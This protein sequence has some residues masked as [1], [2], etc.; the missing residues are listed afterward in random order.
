MAAAARDLPLPSPPLP[1]G[2]QQQQALCAAAGEMGWGR[3]LGQGLGVRGAKGLG[4]GMQDGRPEN[5]DPQH[6]HSGWGHPCPPGMKRGT[7]VPVQ[8][9]RVIRAWGGSENRCRREVALGRSI[10][11]TPTTPERG[12]RGSCR[13]GRP[14]A[15]SGGGDSCQRMRRWPRAAAAAFIFKL[16]SGQRARRGRGPRPAGWPPP[17]PSR[18]PATSPH[19][20]SAW[21]PAYLGER[22]HPALHVGHSPWLRR[23]WGS[24]GS[25]RRRRR[26]PAARTGVPRRITPGPARRARLGDGGTPEKVGAASAGGLRGSESP[27]ARCLS[28]PAAIPLPARRRPSPGRGPT[29]LYRRGWAWPPRWRVPSATRGGPFP[30]ASGTR[31]A[32]RPPC[33][34]RPASALERGPSGSGRLS[35]GCGRG[36]AS[37]TRGRPSRCLPLRPRVGTRH[38]ARRLCRERSGDSPD[39]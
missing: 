16:P 2:P 22:R 24:W 35:C 27:A 12:P 34:P 19:L 38:S 32:A 9:K 11:V 14:S 25:Q 37:A 21:L 5:L 39:A 28:A 31:A 18:G 23:H 7:D 33:S 4:F 1:A 6:I 3:G 8:L 15:R 20:A 26:R 29:L 13:P 10:R 36:D 17:R 30:P